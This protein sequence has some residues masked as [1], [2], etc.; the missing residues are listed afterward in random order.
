MNLTIEQLKFARK[1]GATHVD[2]DINPDISIDS[3]YRKDSYE[4]MD[5]EWYESLLGLSL[6]DDSPYFEKIEF[7]PLDDYYA[8]KALDIAAT[9]IS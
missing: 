1:I 6:L 3:F 7:T 9:G 4:Y 8:D 2:K 5:G